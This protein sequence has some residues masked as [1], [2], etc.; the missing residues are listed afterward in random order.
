M[1]YKD[2]TITIIKV[3]GFIATVQ[4]TDGSIEDIP[5]AEINP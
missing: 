4:Y 5:A 1:T 3:I 2:Q